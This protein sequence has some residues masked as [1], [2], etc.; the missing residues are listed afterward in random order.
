MAQY[1]LTS[2][3]PAYPA[4]LSDRE[5][6]QFVPIYRAVNELARQTSDAAGL[7]S[8]TDGELATANPVTNLFA[9]R[10]QRLI[11][12]AAVP[13][14]YGVAVTVALSSG[15]FIAN[16]ASNAA[17]TTPCFGIVDTANG[18]P[19]NGHGEIVFMSGLCPGVTGSVFGEFYYLATDGLLQNT[20]PTASL[21]QRVGIGMGS[22]GLY[23]LLDPKGL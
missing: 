20:V 4:G 16:K 17:T 3:L 14:A 23:L 1:G 2:G 19:A 9:A 22:Y 6:A 7:V 11:V 15:V 18:I 12:K 8:Y 13:L 5:A 10:S 21:V